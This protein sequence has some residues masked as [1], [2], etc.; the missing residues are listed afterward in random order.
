MKE[1][2]LASASP[3]RSELLRGCGYSFR[4]MPSDC[5]EETDKELSPEDTVKELAVRKARAVSQKNREAVVLGCDTV[6]YLDGKIL[7]KP[8]SREDAFN[9]LTSLSGRRH[10]VSTGVCITDGERELVFE[11]TTQV[12]FY[13]LTADT[14]N[15]YL[16]TEEHKDKAGAYG[17]QG[18][19]CALVKGIRGDYFSVMGLPL[20]ECIR[21]LGTF[22]I[23]G[24][25]KI[26]Q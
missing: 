12:E 25:V 18:Y 6:V 14:I 16:D 24:R 13:P 3:R 19:G 2:I 22:G 23:Y 9:M 17:I 4:I 15:S 20:S 1:L 5:D 10:K 7:G 21:A 8:E 11:N 26:S